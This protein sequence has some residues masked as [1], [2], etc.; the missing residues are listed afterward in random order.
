VFL[1]KKDNILM[2]TYFYATQGCCPAEWADDKISALD[3]LGKKVIL[4]SSISS[5]KLCNKNVKHYRIPSLSLIDL[6]HEIDDLKN[7]KQPIPRLALMLLLP[8]ILTIGI[9]LDLLQ[10][11]IT[12]G[13][14]GGKWSWTFPVAIC[15]LY[16]SIRY[17]CGLIFTTGGPAGAHLAGVFV[18]FFT[19]TRLVCELQDPLTGKDIGRTSRSALFLGYVEKIM[20]SHANKIVY[21]TYDAARYVQNKYQNIRADVVGIHPGSKNFNV[22][23]QLIDGDKLTI[24]HLGT[25]YSTRN[26]YTLIEAIDSLI[27]EKEITK[28]DIEILNLGEIYGDLREH[29]LSRPYISYEPIRP[30]EEA[31]KIASGYMVSLLVQHND[32]RSNATIPYKTYDYLNISN[33]ILALTN[34]IELRDMM[35]NNGHIAVD[36]NNIEEIRKSLLSLINNYESCKNA[37]KLKTIDI[38][39]QTKEIIR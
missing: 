31:I 10:K 26:L 8:F 17:R 33:P 15:A 9:T 7:D 3:H 14:G 20:L 38:V 4:L 37:V 5:K 25:L 27:E 6:R 23:S 24:I 28:D 32:S 11:Y 35:I 19:R 39:K 22:K 34:S 18:K 1:N 13:N 16:L 2:I 30:R 21:V 29:H 12:S 36:I